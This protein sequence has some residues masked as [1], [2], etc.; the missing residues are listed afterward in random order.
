MTLSKALRTGNLISELGILIVFVWLLALTY[1]GN[2]FGQLGLGA[3]LIVV[4]VWTIA[5][6]KQIWATYLRDW[7]RRPKKHRSIWNQPLRFY[8]YFNLIFV[9]P[10]MIALGISLIYLA[11]LVPR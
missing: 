9:L 10:A 6:S 11:S 8:Y 3:S 4:G 7:K 1:M 2:L 5:Q